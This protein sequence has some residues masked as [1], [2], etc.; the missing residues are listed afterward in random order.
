MANENFNCTDI[1]RLLAD[2][3]TP[4]FNFEEQLLF[5]ARADPQEALEYLCLLLRTQFD[6]QT[7]QDGESFF[8]DCIFDYYGIHKPF[9]RVVVASKLPSLVNGARTD[10]NVDRHTRRR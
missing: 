6:V 8:H 2:K 3:V 10:T 4:E 7:Q 1:A 5:I 9:D